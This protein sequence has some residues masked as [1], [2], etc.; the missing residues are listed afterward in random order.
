MPLLLAAGCAGTSS[1]L[2]QPLEIE[3]GAQGVTRLAD[4]YVNEFINRFPEE[5]FSAGFT[6][7]ND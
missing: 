6:L 4:A 1:T 5:A 3:I 2:N 7:P